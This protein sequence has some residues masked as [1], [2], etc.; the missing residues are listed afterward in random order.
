MTL[1]PLQFD[2]T[3]RH[4]RLYTRNYFA[5]TYDKKYVEDMKILLSNTDNVSIQLGDNTLNIRV[6]CH[7]AHTLYYC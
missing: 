4:P 1:I 3:D 2:T 6:V 7:Q 5:V